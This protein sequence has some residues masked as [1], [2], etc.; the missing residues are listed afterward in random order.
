MTKRDRQ[1]ARLFLILAVV[2]AMAC[3]AHEPRR[4]LL[5]QVFANKTFSG[6]ASPWTLDRVVYFGNPP[7]IVPDWLHENS[8]VR[9][10]GY[11]NVPR[12]GSYLLR[13]TS[14]DGTQ[15]FL[16]SK[17]LL[18]NAGDHRP[19]GV[20]A[21]IPLTE[22]QHP[23]RI[24]Y[25]QGGGGAQF[26]LEW[27]LP[28]GYN[29]LAV[30]PVS[31]LLPQVSPS[32]RLWDWALRQAPFWLLLAALLAWQRA[33]LAYFLQQFR[34]D[35][36]VRTV[37]LAGAFVTLL[38]LSVRLWDL[39]GAGETCDE[40]A[41]TGAGRIYADNLVAGIFDAEQWQAN[42]EHPAVG[43]LLYAG[44]QFAFGASIGTFR[45][46]AAVLNAA[47]I[48]FTFLAGWRLGNV[49]T[50]LAAGLFLALLP[51]FI[52]H[53]KV[54]G[55]DAPAAFFFTLSL[56]LLLE[57]LR[58][59]AHRPRIFAWLSLVVGLAVATKLTNVVVFGFVLVA[60]PLF[61]WR[62]IRRTGE[63]RTPAGLA[64]LPLIVP[65]VFV[66]TWPWLWSKPV[67]H[68]VTTLGH[69]GEPPA[70]LFLGTMVER[71][72][73]T[74]FLVCFAAV[75]PVVAAVAFAAGVFTL[76]R[77]RARFERWQIWL[78]W[79]W[80]LLPF[81]W[82]VAGFRQDGIRYVYAAFPPFALFCGLGIDGLAQACTRTFQRAR[83]PVGRRV[84][85]SI[86]LSTVAIS[87]AAADV[88]IHPYYLDYFSEMAGGTSGVYQRK[89]FETGWWGEG[90]DRAEAWLNQH[91]TK[92]ASWGFHGLVD[93]VFIHLRSD[94]RQE[95][96]DPDYWIR[97]DLGPG[98]EGIT[99]YTRVWTQLADG[100]P[101]VAVYQRKP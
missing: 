15:L 40:W 11:L 29:T 81:A 100:A 4:G 31:Q 37:A 66:L 34:S 56:Y 19:T 101:I 49:V 43:K 87:L 90:S 35:P 13:A 8:S 75:T 14:D 58:S 25:T 74:Y 84:I 28:S 69:W 54:A 71:L 86:L 53:G 26:K 55:L 32:M 89:L 27:R 98:N 51:P 38:G 96:T 91:A 9:W 77:R 23:L 70:Q 78:L 52:A 21:E 24:D 44:W 7:S 20:E 1:T 57:G 97:A 45:C 73:V 12:T 68:L 10:R 95:K 6:Q 65:T 63:V 61:T 41:Y 46:L 42:R 2:A 30:V 39:N 79:G 76:V 80:L 88:R 18:D 3:L 92:G 47:T 83:V 22:G 93:H 99:G 82:S 33:A 50:G 16:D 72:P 60:W 5:R 94:L 36:D 59:S 48:L 85:V 67:A 64:F 62:E 17:L